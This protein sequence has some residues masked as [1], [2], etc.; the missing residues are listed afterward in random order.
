MAIMLVMLPKLLLLDLP[1]EDDARCMPMNAAAKLLT[2]LALL[3]VEDLETIT[4]ATVAPVTL[5]YCQKRHRK[6]KEKRV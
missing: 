5:R 6:G 3:P 4:W 1:I 2:N